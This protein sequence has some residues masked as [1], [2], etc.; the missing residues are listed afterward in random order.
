M[1]HTLIQT[2]LACSSLKPLRL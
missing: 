2:H 1:R